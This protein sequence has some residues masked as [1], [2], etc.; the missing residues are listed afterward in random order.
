MLWYKLLYYWCFNKTPVGSGLTVP[1]LVG[2][3]RECGEA[4]DFNID[5]LFSEFKSLDNDYVVSVRFCNNIGALVCCLD[6]FE[7]KEKEYYK[8]FG[9]LFLDDEYFIHLDVFNDVIAFFRNDYL[10]IIN[11]KKYSIS[12]GEWTNFSKREIK[13]IE[14]FRYFE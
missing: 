6:I 11:R 12:N 2:A 4:K 5:D 8:G 7:E 1:F 13:L 14:K 9:S 3:E 10:T